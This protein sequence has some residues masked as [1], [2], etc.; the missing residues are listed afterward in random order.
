[1]KHLIAALAILLTTAFPLAAQAD[2]ETVIID[3]AGVISQS[4]A[5]ADAIRKVEAEGA[6]VRVRTIQT[7]RPAPTLDAYKAAEQK[8][9]ASWRALDGGMKNNLIVLM[10]AMKDRKVGLYFGDQWRS[11]LDQR[12]PGINAKM[13]PRFRD[14]DFA[15]GLAFGL[16]ETASAIHTAVAPATPPTVVIVPSSPREPLDLRWLLWLV[17][18]AGGLT[19]AWMIGRAVQ[20]WQKIQSAKRGAQQAARMA[21]GQCNA[22]V[23]ELDEAFKILGARLA[24]FKAIK[25]GLDLQECFATLQTRHTGLVSQ[26]QQ[27]GQVSGLDETGLSHD[28]YR[29]LANTYTALRMALQK[30]QID[31]ATLDQQ[32]AALQDRLKKVPDEVT[33]L[34]A[35]A[36]AVEKK[37]QDGRAQFDEIAASFAKSSWEAIRGNGTE[38]EKRL[39]QVVEQTLADVPS[40]D[41]WKDIQAIDEAN[42]WLDEAES[43][44]RSVASLHENLQAAKRDAKKEMDEAATDIDKARAFV[45]SHGGGHDKELSQAGVVFEK[46]KTELTDGSPPDY[47]KVV[48]WFNEAERLADTVLAEVQAEVEAA[49]RRKRLAATSL[50]NAK[51]ALDTVREYIED[52]D[53]DVGQHARGLMGMAQ[54]DL[55]KAKAT[56]DLDQVIKYAD[57]AQRSAETAL[58]EAK[59]DFEDAEDRRRPKYRDRSDTYVFGSWGSSHHSSSDPGGSSSFGGSSFGGGGSSGF[60]GSS[61]GGGGSSGW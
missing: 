6:E 25:P 37:I 50:R 51:A 53:R 34:K 42:K 12:W 8:R 59:Q 29:N 19:A 39:K 15:G 5:I 1:M 60:G 41:P 52:H 47:L 27:L 57:S 56:A 45:A 61:G 23:M 16:T 28:E 38:A 58:R 48:N 40:D 35:R 14:G 55:G 21:R 43:F 24:G 18:I 2:C 44:M 32:V 3:E 20:A 36:I 9:C 33:N 11:I 10:L 22:L 46:A 49:E 4:T 7:F 30:L 54:L 26:A 13:G 17:L 31:L